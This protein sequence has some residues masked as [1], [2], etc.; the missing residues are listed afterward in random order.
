L[1]FGGRIKFDHELA[2]VTE[3]T[4]CEAPRNDRIAKFLAPAPEEYFT[5]EVDRID[6]IVGR[7][8]GAERNLVLPFGPGTA[9]PVEPLD[10]RLLAWRCIHD[11]GISEAG[12]ESSLI[13]V[14]ENSTSVVDHDI[15]NDVQP[16]RVSLINKFNEFSFRC[17]RCAIGGKPLIDPD[18]ILD[19]VTV[20][21]VFPVWRHVL[22]NRRKPDCLRTQVSHVI[23][24]RG[25]TSKGAS[26]PEIKSLIPGASWR[27]LVISESVDH[28]EVNPGISPI[29]R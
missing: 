12:N 13:D 24:L 27:R 29:G 6:G 1:T 28:Q 10:W 5:P 14:V 23:E 11:L 20:V 7:K 18:E 3:I 21:I 25:Y 4:L 15:E 22:Q 19:A 16:A 2:H 26:L 17:C 8:M 9:E